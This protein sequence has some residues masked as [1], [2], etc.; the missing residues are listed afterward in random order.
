MVQ[1][2]RNLAALAASPHNTLVVLSGRERALLNEWLGDL[3]IWL[4]AE[5][6][7]WIRPPPGWE[8]GGGGGGGAAATEAAAASRRT[9]K[10]SSG[11]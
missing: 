1:V 2:R 9:H 4:V 8:S 6:G 3:P 7:L 5:N 10:S 11:T